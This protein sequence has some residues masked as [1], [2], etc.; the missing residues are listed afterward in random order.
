MVSSYLRRQK[1]VCA[2]NH[3]SEVAISLLMA[4]R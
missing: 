4:P 1:V 3:I 2:Q